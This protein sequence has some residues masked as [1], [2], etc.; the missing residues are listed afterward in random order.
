[1]VPCLIQTPPTNLDAFVADILPEYRRIYGTDAATVYQRHAPAQLGYTISHPEIRAYAMMDGSRAAALLFFRP[2]QPRNLISF[3]HVLPEGTTGEIAP[4]LL[5]YAIKDARSLGREP[6]FTDYIPFCTL[7][8]A[9][10]FEKLGFSVVERQLM[11][12]TCRNVHGVPVDGYGVRSTTMEHGVDLAAVLYNSYVNHRDQFL[13]AEVASPAAAQTFLAH[14]VA[15]LYGACPPEFLIGAW[16]G[17]QCVG[18]AIGSEVVAG[19][20]FVLHMAV[21][22]A[23]QGRGLGTLLLQTLTAKFWQ[24]GLYTAGLGVTCTNDAVRLYRR[25][26]F[27]PV[28]QFPVYYFDNP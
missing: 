26:G 6:V 22:S 16:Q 8:V 19:M 21:L 11:R 15:G 1:M 10:S 27:E 9:M 25:A 17:N 28:Q 5:E 7:D 23:H 24:A 2:G 18:L 4:T 20:G 3:F 12:R 13:F 14:S